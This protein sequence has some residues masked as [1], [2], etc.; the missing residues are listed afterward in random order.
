MRTSA[1]RYIAGTLLSPPCSIS[2]KNAHKRKNPVSCLC[3]PPR[4]A[5]AVCAAAHPCSTE[6][7][8]L[9]TAISEPRS[10]HSNAPVQPLTSSGR[11]MT[12]GQHHSGPE[13]RIYDILQ[14]LRTCEWSLTA[15]DC[16][17][18]V[19]KHIRGCSLLPIPCC[20]RGTY[21]S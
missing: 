20:E 19:C 4:P 18:N 11:A 16:R 12:A 3:L 1:H 21:L 8:K 10:P 13:H 9:H 2:H 7:M 6:C 5:F 14:S 17:M 15:V